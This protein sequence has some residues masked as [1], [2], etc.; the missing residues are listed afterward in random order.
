LVV[1][2]MTEAKWCEGCSQA[3]DCKRAYQ[4]LGN[5]GGP[6]VA[7]KAGIAFMLPIGLFVATLGAFGRLLQHVVPSRYQTLCAFALAVC[8]TMGFMLIVSC[9]TKRLDRKQG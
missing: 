2:T 4:Q 5:L 8:A 9:I 7:G 6:S 1:K 3:H